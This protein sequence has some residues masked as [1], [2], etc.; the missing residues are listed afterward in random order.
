ML[1]HSGSFGWST[2][3]VPS[4]STSMSTGK[5]TEKAMHM[6]THT[7]M[8]VPH[9]KYI[10][11]VSWVLCVCPRNP[12]LDLKPVKIF[13]FLTVD[14]LKKAKIKNQNLQ[15]GLSPRFHGLICKEGP[16]LCLYTPLSPA[17][18]HWT[19]FFATA[20]FFAE[21]DVGLF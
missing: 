2:R 4:V 12:V 3:E 7:S 21:L 14:R 9:Q 6:M 10:L 15:N 16:F 8:W 11:Y 19:H 17:G 5:S 13:G 1:D 20:I 18:T